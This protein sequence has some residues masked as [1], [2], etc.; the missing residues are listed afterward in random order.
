MSN[1]NPQA[2][3]GSTHTPDIIALGRPRQEDHEFKIILGY[4]SSRPFRLQGVMS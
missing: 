1:I 3:Q 4:M 2:R